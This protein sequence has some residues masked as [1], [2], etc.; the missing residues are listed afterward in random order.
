MPGDIHPADDPDHR[1]RAV[2]VM[3]SA[4]GLAARLVELPTRKDVPGRAAHQRDNRRLPRAVPRVAVSGLAPGG[5]LL[6][7]DGDRP[8]VVGAAPDFA[9]PVWRRAYDAACDLLAQNHR[10]AAVP[11]ISVVSWSAADRQPRSTAI[12]WLEYIRDKLEQCM[13]IINYARRLNQEGNSRQLKRGVHAS[14]PPIEQ[15]SW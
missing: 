4:E 5:D 1:P 11:R 3:I 8:V 15:A 9:Y 10:L 14:E 6:E 7:P 12:T 2:T 13:K